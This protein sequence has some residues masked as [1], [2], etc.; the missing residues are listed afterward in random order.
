MDCKIS[1]SI[2]QRRQ[3]KRDMR[4][5]NY[6]LNSNLTTMVAQIYRDEPQKA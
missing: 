5:I 6:G 1:K 3:Q 4:N 2:R